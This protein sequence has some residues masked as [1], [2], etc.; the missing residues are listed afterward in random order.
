MGVPVGARTRCKRDDCRLQTR[1]RR[2]DDD[3]VLPDLAGEIRRR[4]APRARA[5]PR[6][7][8]IGALLLRPKFR[9]E[10]R[11]GAAS[12]AMSAPRA[13]FGSGERRHN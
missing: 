8:I 3:L 10:N 9:A 7:T 12:A 2:A 1:R 11:S 13:L 5:D 4:T 6:T